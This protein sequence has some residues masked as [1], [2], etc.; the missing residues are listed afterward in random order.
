[1]KKFLKALLSPISI[2]NIVSI[3]FIYFLLPE[4]KKAHPSRT[5]FQTLIIYFVLLSIGYSFF[6]LSQYLFSK[7]SPYLGRQERENKPL[8]NILSGIIAL[9]SV[10]F[11]A[12]ILLNL[13]AEATT[14]NKLSTPFILFMI[15]CILSATLWGWDA[16]LKKLKNT[17][18]E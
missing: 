16:F 12:K 7:I 15:A 13:G 1:M 4:L 11:P 6:M 9:G 17:T 8:K 2:S 18:L 3:V 10:Y 14:P 5:L